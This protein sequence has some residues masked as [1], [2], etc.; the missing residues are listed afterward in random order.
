MI[1]I[2]NEMCIFMGVITPRKLTG[3][4]GT[5]YFSSKIIHNNANTCIIISISV[6]KPAKIKADSSFLMRFQYLMCR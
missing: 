6:E 1:M 4:E 5:I 3:F 2:T